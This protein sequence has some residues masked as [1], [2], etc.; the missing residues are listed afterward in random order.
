[1]KV[2]ELLEAVDEPLL[3]SM[4]RK[5]MAAG[6]KIAWYARSGTSPIWI[7]KW[8]HEMVGEEGDPA[9]PQILTWVIIGYL[10][11]VEM[12]MKLIKDVDLDKWTLVAGGAKGTMTLKRREQH[13]A[14]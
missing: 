7:A 13:E 8:R 11:S 1:M 9:N 10:R 3:F 4:M 5:A 14:Q 12:Q 2:S 6:K